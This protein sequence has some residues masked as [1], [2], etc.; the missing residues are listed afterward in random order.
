MSE[1]DLFHIHAHMH[2][3]DTRYNIKSQTL[4]GMHS[5]EKLGLP[6]NKCDTKMESLHLCILSI[7]AMVTCLDTTSG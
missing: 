4:L 6:G 5:R 7:H 2:L 3:H 1:K